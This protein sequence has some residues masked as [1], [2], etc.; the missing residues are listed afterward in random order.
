MRILL[1]YPALDY[2]KLDFR[3]LAGKDR[4]PIN[5]GLLYL[6]RSAKELG[7]SV[8]VEVANSYNVEK[9]LKDFEPDLVGITCMSVQYSSCKKISKKVKS[10][11]S[12]IELAVGGYHPTFNSQAVMEETNVDYI[13]VG[14]SGKS[15]ERFLQKKAEGKKIKKRVFR[16][17]K[18]N[19]REL[20]LP[21]R[22]AVDFKVPIIYSSRGCPHSCSFCCIKNFYDGKFERREVEDV[23]NE[24]KTLEKE[25]YRNVSFV[26]DNFL[27]SAAYVEKLCK[28][29]IEERIDLRL[30]CMARPDDLV[31]NRSVID[32]MLQAGFVRV[33]VGL[34]SLRKSKLEEYNVGYTQDTLEKFFKLCKDYQGRLD[35]LLYYILDISSYREINK[36]KKAI[37]ANFDRINCKNIKV[38][39]HFLTPLQGTDLYQEGE[40]L[41]PDV[42][43]E[44]ISTRTID[45]CGEILN[46]WYRRGMLKSKKETYVYGLFQLFPPSLLMYYGLNLALSD[47]PLTKK[48]KLFKRLSGAFLD[49]LSSPLFK[50]KLTLESIKKRFLLDDV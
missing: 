36:E 50:Q 27:T 39:Y 25:G 14:P 40:A 48:S 32:L 44:G 47:M 31:R 29:I 13:F 41:M 7:H 2:G 37:I 49:E 10:Y 35:F 16:N 15:W 17:G 28:R 9:Y 3:M 20:S 1:L 45:K 18:K 26:D 4:K 42:C 23:I 46:Y 5:L 19:I 43:L 12:Q 8:E 11:D 21:D 38:D 24:L 22:G 6:S 34:E 30:S 33:S